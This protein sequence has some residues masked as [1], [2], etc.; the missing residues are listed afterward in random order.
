MNRSPWKCHTYHTSK[1]LKSEHKTNPYQAIRVNDQVLCWWVWVRVW[2]WV[3]RVVDVVDGM[4]ARWSSARIAWWGW[5]TVGRWREGVP[6]S[7]WSGRSARRRGHVP[8]VTF[9]WKNKVGQYNKLVSSSAMLGRHRHKAN[10]NVMANSLHISQISI[11]AQ[12]IQFVHSHPLRTTRIMH[13]NQLTT[14]HQTRSGDGRKFCH[15][16]RR[17]GRR[18]V[19]VAYITVLTT[20]CV[21]T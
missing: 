14:N 13:A 12:V 10:N 9:I 11:I 3:G 6:R 15:A 1:I 7:E 21:D 2:V 19:K 5:E 18:D 16:G 4:K 17:D 20:N 8:N